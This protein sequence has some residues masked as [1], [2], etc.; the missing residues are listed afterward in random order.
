MNDGHRMDKHFV[1]GLYVNPASGLLR[2]YDRKTDIDSD[3]LHY[4]FELRVFVDEQ[5][6]DFE[7]MQSLSI[8][9]K[10]KK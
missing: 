7:K 9:Q 4:K 10:V 6:D 3:G 1:P 8:D 5:P 2:A